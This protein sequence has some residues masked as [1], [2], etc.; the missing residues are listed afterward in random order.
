MQYNIAF[1]MNVMHLYNKCTASLLVSQ[2]IKS[3]LARVWQTEWW[4]IADYN[5]TPV[6]LYSLLLHCTIVV[7]Q[8]Y[9]VVQKKT[10]LIYSVV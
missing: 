7:K 6:W 8:S 1:N 5:S 9:I 2:K 4:L 3:K 10:T